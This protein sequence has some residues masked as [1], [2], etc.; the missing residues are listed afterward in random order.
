MY[1]LAVV[2]FQLLFLRHVPLQYHN[3]NSTKILLVSSFD[4][5]SCNLRLSTLYCPEAFV[6]ETINSSVEINIVSY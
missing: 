2:F 3:S 1:F 6:K 5:A 4:E